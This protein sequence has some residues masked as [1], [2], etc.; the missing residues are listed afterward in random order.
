M[1]GLGNYDLN[2]KLFPKIEDFIAQ[3]KK[4]III[5]T[6]NNIILGYLSET[7]KQN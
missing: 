3:L 4:A 2:V 7:K 5:L 6:S 1:Q